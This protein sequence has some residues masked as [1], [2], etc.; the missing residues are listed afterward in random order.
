LTNDLFDIYKDLQDGSHTLATRMTNAN[1]FN[2]FFLALVDRFKEEI[3]LLPYNPAAKRD[4]T[5]S[6]MG[7][8][9][10]G[11]IALAQLRTI[12]G[13]RLSLP[14]LETL[15]RKDLIIDMEKREN[16]WRWIK[17]VYHF[18]KL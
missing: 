5:M 14:K 13:D 9:A 15:S 3:K 2:Q 11:W 8:C 12:Q 18:G 4:F 17:W 1:T 10:F 7:I 16:L 6:M